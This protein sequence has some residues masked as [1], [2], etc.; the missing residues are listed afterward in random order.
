MT[1]LTG[2]DL[3]PNESIDLNKLPRCCVWIECFDTTKF[4]HDLDNQGV[5]D[6]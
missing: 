4:P 6:Q 3:A 1:L 5:D 2:L